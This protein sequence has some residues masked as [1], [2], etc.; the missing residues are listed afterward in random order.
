MTAYIYGEI[1][2]DAQRI[3][4]MAESDA[5]D[6]ATQLSELGAAAAL[7][8]LTTPLYKPT[9]P[10][11]AQWLPLTWPA[12][13]QLSATY[14]TAWKPGPAL[15]EWITAQI[16][17][18]SD[19][20]GE[21]ATTLP[22]GLVPRT[23]QVAA[24]RMIGLLGSALLFDDPGTGKTIS[25]IL[26]LLERDAAGHVVLPVV[27]VCPNAVQDSWVEHFHRWAP[28]WRVRAW[29]GT[30]QQRIRMRSTADVYVSSYG[31]ARMDAQDTNV[32]NNHNPLLGVG[33]VT[34]VADE[35]H[36]LKS[37]ASEQSRAVR[38][39]AAKA[40]SFIG[41]SGTPITHHPG[42]L[43][44]ALCAM[45]PG[46]YPS[47]ERWVGRYC[48]TVQ[49]AYTQTV[50]GLAD[51]REPEFRLTLLGQYR[52][53]AK[54]DVLTE[55][56]PKVYSVRHV[57]IPEAY[58]KAYDAM[59]ADMLAELPGDNDGPGGELT[60]M[61]VL[62]QMTRLLQLAAAAADVKVTYETVEDPEVPGLM[63][64]RPHTEV[65][66][67]APSWK[68]DALLEVLAERPDQQVIAC[69]P[70][71]QLMMLAG[72]QA[73][74]K[75]YRVGYVVGGQSAK[76]RTAAINAFQAGELD[77]ICVTTQAGG[78]GITLTAASTVVF[79]Q[80]PW[81]LVDS[82]QMEDRAHRIGSERHQSIEVIDILAKNTIETRVR[83]VL[84]DR[85][86]QLSR[87]VEDPRIVRELLGGD[88]VKH[89]RSGRKKAA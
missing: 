68:V 80:R 71:R 27:V 23:Y 22:P 10:A 30:P 21:L 52:R 6:N 16:I 37:Q 1:T 75:G 39:L 8:Q 11:G 79:L 83:S 40:S 85:A 62:A 12:I 4:L 73:K 64:E 25:T 61:T 74:A 50:L 35:V 82:L 76:E 84:K 42:D 70:S 31:T 33:P 54:A 34:V 36:K 46:A 49:G 65:K 89:I 9:D 57:E 20:G 15:A 18:R 58:R 66:L 13:V 59:E 38:R 32:R 55:L 78:V 3:I 81:S 77:L 28:R 72:V 48:T 44:P 7:Q 29:R 24:A 45:E 2:A 14:G 56:P 47:R 67:K 63:V 60:A 87:L 19:Q 69:A 5:W 53:V 51:H 41:L 26:G 86:D 43:W 17:A 88:N